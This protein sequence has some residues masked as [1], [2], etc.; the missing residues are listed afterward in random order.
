M[1][2]A[3][4]IVRLL[5]ILLGLLLLLAVATPLVGAY[6]LRR[7]V[8]KG[9]LVQQIEENINAR[10]HI[11]DVTLTL[12]TWPPSL[13]ISGFKVAPR[14]EYVGRPLAERPPL[15]DAPLKVDMAYA[16]LVPGA[17][18]QKNFLP[19]VIRFIGV[20]VQESVSPDKGS[21]LEKLF[22]RPGAAAVAT[23][24]SAVPQAIPVQPAP[25][26][27]A[28]E[29]PP[30]LPV[31]GEA[32]P[33][34]SQPTRFALQ[35]IS[36]EQGR[37][38]VTNQSADAR[39]DGEISD[40]NLFITEIDIDP[41][42]LGGH[43]HLK[44]RLGAKAVLDGVAQI[45][46]RMQQVRFADMRVNGEG[47]VNPIDP[48]T[49]SWS[50]A[51]MLK[52]VIDR[53]SILG[54]HM[55]IGDAAGDQLEKLMKYGID[56]R[57]IRIG[58]PLSQ[59]L[60]VNV[61][62]RNQQITFLDNANLVLPDYAVTVKR[63]SWINFAKD[64]QGLS[65]RLYCGPAL[66]EQVVRGVAARGLGDT[67]SRMIVDGFSDDQ[68]RLSFDLTITGT[69]SHPQVKPDIQRRLEGLL[70]G[71][72]EEKAKGLIDTFKGLKGLFKKY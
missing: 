39:F 59:D 30:A 4:K 49:M 13:R 27:V 34:S 48:A 37:F 57:G 72:L 65:T 33:Q 69:L 15:A 7:Y 6:M 1:L 56:L 14:D 17:L 64:D 53:V 32:A 63:D 60:A 41:A 2:A 61:L 68:G 19:R 47:N 31:Q 23:T 58:G 71:D 55:T 28:N 10:V 22:V 18:L 36:I 45:G 24:D 38:R 16:E 54:G 51:A 12:F 26:V 52:L 5:L 20:D 62:A 40:F 50:P 11:D 8:D 3:M 35:E 67:I 29:P 9:F 70:G 46:G 42:D 43:N 44:V 25:P 21:A 66:K